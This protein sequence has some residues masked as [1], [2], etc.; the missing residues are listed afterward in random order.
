LTAAC[1][2][3]DVDHGTSMT[4]VLV[5]MLENIGQAQFGGRSV[6]ISVLWP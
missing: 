6:I 3:A 4:V 2:T 1:I 5:L